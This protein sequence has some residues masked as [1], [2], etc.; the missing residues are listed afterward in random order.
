GPPRK[1]FCSFW[2]TM[3][4]TK[5]SVFRRPKKGCAWTEIILLTN[6]L[7][8]ILMKIPFLRSGMYTALAVALAGCGSSV[9]AIVSTPIENIDQMPLKVS[10]LTEEQLRSWPLADLASDTIPG[11]SVEKAYREIIKNHDGKT[12]IVGVVDSGVD[13]EH[14]DL[15][16]VIWTNEDEIPNNGKDDDRNG[17]V[18]DIHGWNFLG[19]AVHEN[20][21]F[22]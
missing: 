13:I 9:P 15:D 1:T 6:S 22:V 17:Y 5:S 11:M 21:E 2:S 8:K 7:I 19:D 4:T 12:V 18:D 14:E 10:E 20:L 3:P 16:G